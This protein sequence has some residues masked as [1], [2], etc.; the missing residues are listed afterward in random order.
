M[1]MEVKRRRRIAVPVMIGASAMA[2]GLLI[3]ACAM[4]FTALARAGSHA[5][6]AR[7][8]LQSDM[9]ILDEAS[10]VE[11][12]MT[13]RKA[14]LRRRT[15]RLFEAPERVSAEAAVLRYVAD[16]AN[17][18]SVKRNSLQVESDEPKKNAAVIR[19]VASFDYE[20]EYPQ[21]VEYLRL[22]Q[23]P[24]TEIESL[25]VVPVQHSFQGDGRSRIG[26]SGKVAFYGIM[27]PVKGDV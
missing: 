19:V 26:V 6:T 4:T 10:Y 11:S 3:Y 5:S 7:E 24:I 8:L 2:G 18:A 23:A 21:I 13:Q 22:L 17:L 27:S 12:V 14:E 25:R 20:G 15:L 9:A 16:A 1:T